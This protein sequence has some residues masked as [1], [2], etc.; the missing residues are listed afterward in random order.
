MVSSVPALTRLGI[1]GFD[2]LIND[3]KQRESSETDGDSLPISSYI[4]SDA[5][6]RFKL[7]A[8]NIGASQEVHMKT[9]LEARLQH[10]PDVK[11]EIC[12]LL[13]VMNEALDDRKSCLISSSLM[14]FFR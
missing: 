8:G 3:L 14:A 13:E 10:V 4:V 2:Q 7:W 1:L 5:L 9:S 6:D 12:Q 11:T